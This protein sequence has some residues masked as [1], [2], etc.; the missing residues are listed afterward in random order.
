[1]KGEE[2]LSKK[3]NLRAIKRRKDAEYDYSCWIEENEN[4]ESIVPDGPLFSVVLFAGEATDEQ[5]KRCLHSVDKQSYKNIQRVII[6]EKKIS[7]EEIKTHLVG[8]Y[9]VFVSMTDWLAPNAISEV[10]KL[11]KEQVDAHWVYSDEDVYREADKKRVSPKFKPE[12]S[13]DTLMSFFYTGN[14]AA[15][16]TEVCQKISTWEST[17]SASW[18][19]DFSLR[20][21]EVCDQKQIY[22]IS[23]VLYHASDS[24]NTE[25][26]EVETNREELKHI[27]NDFI[28]R[29][30]IKA[31]IE[32]EPCTKEF[33]MVYKADGKVSIVIPSKDNVEMLLHG[34]DS[35]E[36]NTDYKD[37]EIIVVDN[38][39]KLENK[40]ILEKTL[41][42][43]SIKYIYEPMVFNF[44]RMCNM[45]AKAA[46]GN[47]ILFLNDDIECIDGKWLERM[48]GQ[49]AQQG[50]GAVGAK[51]LYP[52]DNKIQHIGVVNLNMGPSHILTK[53]ED[54]GVLA[55]G[56]NRLDYN[57]D[58]VTAACLIV[59]RSV[60]DLVN[61]FD[62][63]LPVSYNDVDFCY[64]LREKGLRN[65]VRT[66]AV[67]I[68]HESIS[69]GLDVVNDEKMQ[70]LAKER[71]YLFSA[72][73]WILEKGDAS[74][75]N[76][77]SMD[78]TD[79]SLKSTRDMREY[80]ERIRR[81]LYAKKPFHVIIDRM[82]KTDDLQITGWYWF[83]S[84]DYT[85]LSDVY[86]VFR[87]EETKKEIWYQT[88]RQVREDVTE[89]LNN[90]AIYCGFV[91]KI[92]K[93]T[94]EELR[95]CKV[96]LCVQMYDIKLNLVTWTDV[97][98]D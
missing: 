58:A 46:T 64:R 12:W 70:R 60:Y 54:V 22:H 2:V 32:F 55:Q 16:C 34:I 96:G 31:S 26:T 49:A 18:N 89:V 69:R 86:L 30:G 67:L 39:S 98:V 62:E 33:R 29:T 65:V 76:N 48:L 63:S 52:Q 77:Y 24:R 21:L 25:R 3:N 72:H 17:Y 47:Y 75:N 43:K 13:Y 45:G 97:I 71:A 6:S 27:K 88:Y 82:V 50:V 66:D 20:F 73:P 35:L 14:L 44:S 68:H 61:G 93:E 8:E 90:Q 37:Y 57:Y 81:K 92:P 19:Y 91:C 1:M 38:G 5:K 80:N 40:S 51:L 85:N 94:V 28:Q 9:T 4:G 95:G 36:K 84:D 74:Y 10:A 87:N 7:W 78:Q 41:E 59:K 83:R 23:K 56:R 53:Q 42:E 11:L 79:F 15:Y